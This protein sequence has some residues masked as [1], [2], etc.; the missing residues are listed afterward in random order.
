[1]ASDPG[2]TVTTVS[3][4]YAVATAPG[5]RLVIRQIPLPGQVIPPGSTRV[6]HGQTSPYQGW[7]SHQMLQRIPAPVITMTRRGTSTA[8]LTL[9]APSS[10]GAGLTTTITQQADGSWYRLRIDL[11]GRT[12]S[13]L[14][15]TGGYIEQG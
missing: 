12:T 2:L 15:S 3:R 11:G 9:I 4:S 14:I 1:M 6:I 7:V 8:I 13:F 5:T 10:P